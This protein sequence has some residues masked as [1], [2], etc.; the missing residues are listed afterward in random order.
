MIFEKKMVKK[1][2]ACEIY[3][4]IIIS[5]MILIYPKVIGCLL[6]ANIKGFT[7]SAL[8]YSSPNVTEAKALL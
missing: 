2:L 4:V 8:I 7:W 3:R 6:K 1:Q 5:K